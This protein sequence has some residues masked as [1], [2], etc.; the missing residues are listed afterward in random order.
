[1]PTKRNLTRIAFVVVTASATLVSVAK[2][3][4]QGADPTSPPEMVSAAPATPAA[5]A[6]SGDP[7]I[8]RGFLLPTAMTQ[9]AGSITYNNYELLLHGLTYGITDHVQASVTVLSPIVRDMPFVGFAAVKARVLSTDR[10]HLAVQGDVGWGHA[11]N[12]SSTDANAFSLG[13]GGLASFCLR[14]DCSSLI[15]ASATYQ[16]AFNGNAGSGANMVIYG[17]SIVHRVSQHI[18]LLGEVT[19]AAGKSVDSGGL[20]NIDGVLVGYGVR[21]HTDNIAADLGFLKPFSNGSTDGDFL[22]GL[23]FASV[24]YRWM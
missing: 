5:R 21:F 6:T 1:M 16:Y 22:L 13:A 8:D 17:G 15:S 23:P 11:F 20:Q 18:K 19:S 3:H 10:F 2:A 9:P 14:E 24:S 4:A 12:D 7:N